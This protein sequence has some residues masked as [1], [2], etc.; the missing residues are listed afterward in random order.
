MENLSKEKIKEVI[1]GMINGFDKEHLGS[2]IFKHLIE[3][4][5][6]QLI[7]IKLLFLYLP[8]FL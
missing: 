7:E 1:E 3:K 4:S 6:Y 2:P 8:N 5:E